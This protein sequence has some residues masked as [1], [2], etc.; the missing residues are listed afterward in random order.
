MLPLAEVYIKLLQ[1]Q[2]QDGHADLDNAIIY[3]AIFQNRL[4]N[5]NP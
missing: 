1:S 3:E 5:Q 4:K 2:L